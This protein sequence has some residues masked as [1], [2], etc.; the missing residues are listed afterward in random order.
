MKA[1]LFAVLFLIANPSLV[2]AEGESSSPTP[3]ETTEYGKCQ[4]ITDSAG[5]CTPQNV[6][7]SCT[8]KCSCS[9]GCVIKGTIRA[10]T[11]TGLGE[12]NHCTVSCSSVTCV[13]PGMDVEP[14]YESQPPL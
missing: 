9:S 12:T 4:M 6:G 14:T 7:R 5:G 8:P 2:R 13:P 10:G 11:C 3:D 1:F